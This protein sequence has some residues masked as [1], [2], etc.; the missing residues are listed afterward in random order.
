MPTLLTQPFCMGAALEEVQRRLAFVE[1]DEEDGDGAAPADMDMEVTV[2]KCVREA[3][4]TMYG[5]QQPFSVRQVPQ[6]ACG[7]MAMWKTRWCTCFRPVRICFCCNACFAAC[8]A[9]PKRR[10]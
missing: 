2:G 6:A 9:K 4:K 3:Y 8:F 1:D 7:S 5:E 10:C